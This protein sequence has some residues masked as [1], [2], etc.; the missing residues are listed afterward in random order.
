M[1]TINILISYIQKFLWLKNT[2]RLRVKKDHALFKDYVILFQNKARN[3]YTMASCSKAG[4]N[5]GRTTILIIKTISF[6]GF[7]RYR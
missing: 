5:S 7:D 3:I 4:A 2:L 1:D 6:S